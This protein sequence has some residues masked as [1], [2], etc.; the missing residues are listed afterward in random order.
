MAILARN[1]TSAGHS[2]NWITQNWAKGNDYVDEYSLDKRSIQVISETSYL[3]G[4]SVLRRMISN[5]QPE[6]VM[7]WDIRSSF[8]LIVLSVFS[9]W[10]FVNG[11]I[12]HGV[13][14][15]TFEHKFRTRLANLSP[16]V[17]ANSKAGLRV[18]GMTPGTK[19]KVL[20]NAVDI[21][22]KERGA[23]ERREQLLNESFSD[24]NKNDQVIISV[25][26]LVPY[27]DYPTVLEALAQLDNQSFKYFIIGEG[28]ERERI[29]Q[30]IEILELHNQVRLLGR[31]SD[32]Q[33]LLG[34]ADIFLHSSKG[35]GCSN[36][37]LEAMA[38][39]L[40]V[41][42]S[43]VG[44]TPE[45]LNPDL[46]RLFEFKNKESLTKVL[47]EVMTWDKKSAEFTEIGTNYMKKFSNQ[48]ITKEFENIFENWLSQ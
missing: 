6:I 2:V 19:R 13:V 3:K 39:G 37:I 33:D 17:L 1:L 10:K 44:G 41:I 8:W 24:W 21:P 47:N 34:I 38:A 16:L 42:A 11:S 7:S 4:I 27:K 18:N 25:A 29:E 48:S 40:P 20:Y 43:N 5:I 12:R 45:I 15:D 26:N 32:V 22:E 36:A 31:R 9:K 46:G 35:E 14:K 30:K 28:R 23:L